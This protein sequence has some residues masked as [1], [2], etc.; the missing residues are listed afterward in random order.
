MEFRILGPLEVVEEGH[1]LALAAGKQRAV[2]A[3]LL[4]HANRVV[5]VAELID[6]LWGE[7]PPASAAKSVQI[8][9]SELRKVIG[10]GALLTRRPG[11]LFE[12]ADSEF[13]LARFELLLAKGRSSL[14]SGEADEA[15]MTLRDALSLWRGVPLA[16]FA[17]EPFAQPEIARLEELRLNALEERIKADLVLGRHAD[18]IGELERLVVQHPL[19]ERLRETLMLALYRSGR[20]AEALEL[21]QQTRRLLRNELGLEPGPELHNLQQAILQHDSALAT[22][23][24]GTFSAVRTL[25]AQSTPLVGREREL[26]EVRELLRTFRVVTLTGAGGSGKTRLG[27]QAAANAAEDFPDGV[28]FVS[29]ASLRDARLVEPAVAEAVGAPGDLRAFL[30][31]KDLLLVLDN[32]EQLLPEVAATVA[33]LGVS[34]LATSRERLGISAECEYLVPPLPLPVAQELFVQR[35]RR[36]LPHFEPDE[37]VIEIVHQLAGMPLAVELAAARVKVLTPSQIVQ[38]LAADLGVLATRAHDVPPR[39]RTLKATLDWSHALLSREE[40]R[41]FA[42]LAAFVGGFTLE[43]AESVADARLDTLASLVDK[44]LISRTE[45]RFDMLDVIHQYAATKLTATPEGD[46]TRLR[47]A[48]YF[49]AFANSDGPS[50]QWM[51][52][53][54]SEH[55]NVLAALDYLDVLGF[56]ELELELAVAASPYWHIAGHHALGRM[57]LEGALERAPRATPSLQAKALRQ[58]AS[59]AKDLGD[60][61]AAEGFTRRRLAIDRSEEHSFGPFI[62]LGIAAQQRGNVDEGRA[63]FVKALEKARQAN[64]KIGVG[65]AL[66]N[67]G[68][69][70]LHRGDR[71][72]AKR[73]F[74]K[75]L[76]LARELG[77]PEGIAIVQSNLALVALADGDNEAALQRWHEAFDTSTSIGFTGGIIWTALGVAAVEVKDDAESAAQLLGAADA[78]LNETGHVLEHH[79]RRLRADVTHEAQQQLTSDSYLT[80]FAEGR[81]E[82]AEQLLTQKFRS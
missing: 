12:I 67:L 65:I 46:Q 77:T 33:A 24:R 40:R 41:T 25:P 52:K 6:G 20:Q 69:N 53:M 82:G 81:R 45:E 60:Y 47:H 75:S 55:G 18:L 7:R 32:L 61:S 22:P 48:E 2:L 44:N 50:R 13:D 5:S 43:V 1:S 49:L 63:L 29:A 16:D 23:T 4:L 64:S 80:A 8:Y 68:S 28:W 73:C 58:A 19:R 17:H 36:L 11:Y 76:N 79:E 34:V 30:R 78:L 9:V 59:L 62:A 56:P 10:K 14:D 57:R 26:R 3:M 15:A 27:I 51:L 37:N 35:A 74:R 71:R 70:A 21:Y 42:D 66:T 39:Q 31:G 54:R 72:E 38:R